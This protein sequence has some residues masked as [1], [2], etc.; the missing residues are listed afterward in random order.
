MPDPLKLSARDI[1]IGLAMVLSTAIFGAGGSAAFGVS[2]AEVVRMETKL[3]SAL[4]Q[5][6]A[7]DT[8]IDSLTKDSSRLNSEVAVLKERV[9]Q[10]EKDKGE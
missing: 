10:L 8:K 1:I 5:F 7:Q 2:K 9:S 6:S 3:D 4:I